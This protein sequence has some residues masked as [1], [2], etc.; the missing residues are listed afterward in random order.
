M[1]KVFMDVFQTKGVLMDFRDASK[2]QSKFPNQTRLQTLTSISCLFAN[3]PIMEQK[4]PFKIVSE[5]SAFMAVLLS[6][7]L[8]SPEHKYSCCKWLKPCSGPSSNVDIH[9]D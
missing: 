9:Q 4:G 3:L 5:Y 1:S 2:L 6:N 8:K 7:T